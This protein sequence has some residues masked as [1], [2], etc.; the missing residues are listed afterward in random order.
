[1][2]VVCV[3]VRAAREQHVCNVYVR[4]CEWVGG[5]DVS[6][7][8]RACVCMCGTYVCSVCVSAC[9]ECVCACVIGW[10]GGCMR[11]LVCVCGF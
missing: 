1:M 2:Y 10:V 5:W 3:L 4:V 9:V 7:S 11:A 8:A 6:C